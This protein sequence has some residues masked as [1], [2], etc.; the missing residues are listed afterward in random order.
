[1]DLGAAASHLH[2]AST[3]SRS[4]RRFPGSARSS[5]A[6]PGRRADSYPH[7]RA[8]LDDRE[9]PMVLINWNTDM[10][11]GWEWSNAEEYPGYSGTRPRRTG[12]DQRS[13]L[14][15]DALS[16]GAR[17]GA[18]IPWRRATWPLEGVAEKVGDGTAADP[19]ELRKVIVG[20]D[21]VVEQI[22]IALFAGGHCLI[23][24]V[25]GLA[26]TLLVRTLAEIL[27]LS[28]KRIQFTPDLMPADITGTEILDEDGGVARPPV[29]Q[30]ARLRAHHPRRRDQPHAAQDAGRAARGHAGAPRHGRRPQLSARTAV[31]RARDAEPHRAGRH[32]SAARKRS[33]TG[34]CSTS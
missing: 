15:A 31:L 19:A 27:D 3:S 32:V 34:S 33:S 28:F 24:G 20:Q 17:A 29:R 9:R 10:G 25:P 12:W 1:M 18:S 13:H 7:L 6:A 4:T 5:A 8:V 11:D 23:T 2:A 14:R 16:A 30:G 26:K 21:E 22:L